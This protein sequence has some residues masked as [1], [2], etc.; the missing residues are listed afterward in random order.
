MELNNLVSSSIYDGVGGYVVGGVTD[1]MFPKPVAVHGGNIL[2]EVAYAGGQLV[3]SSFVLS[4]LTNIAIERGYRNPDNVTYRIMMMFGQSQLVTRL[5][6]IGNYVKD[7]L[8][9]G[10]VVGIGIARNTETSRPLPVASVSD[11]Q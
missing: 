1:R 10:M 2:E 4:A 11:V 6:H 7:R 9:N 5:R 3:L 8:S